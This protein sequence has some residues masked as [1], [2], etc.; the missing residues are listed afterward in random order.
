MT[1]EI[2][3][4]HG[5]CKNE[6]ASVYVKLL[7][8]L[9]PSYIG[10]LTKIDVFSRSLVKSFGFIF[11]QTLDFGWTTK[12]LLSLDL[13][14]LLF[15]SSPVDSKSSTVSARMQKTLNGSQLEL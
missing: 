13:F 12:I 1:D 9:L 2:G 15:D 5:L 4:H 7:T 6:A 14:L 10:H 3:D 8:P 11:I